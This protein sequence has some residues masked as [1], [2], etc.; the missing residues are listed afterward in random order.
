VISVTSSPATDGPS[1]LWGATCSKHFRHRNYTQ[2]GG[3]RRL[4]PPTIVPRGGRRMMHRATEPRACRVRRRRGGR[5]ESAEEAFGTSRS[6][7][8]A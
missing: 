5:R 1:A 7:R 4:P 6:R 8:P 3:W 2:R